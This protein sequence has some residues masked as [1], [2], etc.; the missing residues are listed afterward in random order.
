MRSGCMVFHKNI[1]DGGGLHKCAAD[2]C[3]LAHVH[4][5]EFGSRYYMPA[6]TACNVNW[7]QG[8]VYI[9]LEDAVTSFPCTCRRARKSI[10]AKLTSKPRKLSQQ[11]QNW[12]CCKAYFTR[13]GYPLCQTCRSQRWSEVSAE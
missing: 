10:A 12:N 4:T 1:S 9:N 11:C 5:D 6:C 13:S 7:G 2:A 3:L 8:V